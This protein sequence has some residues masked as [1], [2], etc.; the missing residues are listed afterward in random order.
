MSVINLKLVRER[1]GKTVD[2][3]ASAVGVSHSTIVQWENNPNSLSMEKLTQYAS[4]LG[5]EI[6][7]LLKKSNLET[8][9]WE[10]VAENKDLQ[11]K[12]IA[13]KKKINEIKTVMKSEAGQNFNNETKSRYEWTVQ[14]LQNILIMMRKPRIV[15]T[16]SS[17]SGKSTMLNS[18][19]GTNRIS[20]H[21]QPA[22]SQVIRVVHSDDKPKWM[23][24]NTVVI[25]TEANVLIES[26][27]LLDR[28]VY[29]K[30]LIEEGDERL[31]KKYGDR[32]GKDGVDLDRNPYTIFTYLD[33][34]I[35]NSVEIWDTPGISAGMDSEA[36]KEAG[37]SN[38]AQS[39]ADTIIYLSVINQFLH[40]EDIAYL[41]TMIRNLDR[42]NDF[43]EG[44]PAWQNLY[45][46]G[47]QAGIIDNHEAINKILDNGYERLKRTLPVS[48][49]GRDIFKGLRER[50]FTFAN[51]S[52][53]LSSGLVAQ[54][55]HDNNSYQKL[56]DKRA[57]KRV[58][59]VTENLQKAYRKL[60]DQ[61]TK[62]KK[63]QEA[64]RKQAEQAVINLPKIKRANAKAEKESLKEAENQRKITKSEFIQYYEDILES[65]NLVEN[66]NL[67]GF[68]NKKDDKN[69]FI[70]FIKGQSDFKLQ[71]I[72]KNSGEKYAQKYQDIAKEVQVSSDIDKEYFNFK[73]IGIAL[74]SGGIS[75]GAL[76]F[77]SMQI[78]SNL[79]L[80]LAVGSIGG[81]LTNLGIISSPIWLTTFISTTGGPILWGV[82]LSVLA[83][84]LVMEVFGKST[85]KIKLA[86]KTQSIF[87]KADAL[88]KYCLVID[89]YWDDTVEGVKK[90][91][92]A[93]DK[94]AEE[95]A[96][97][98][99]R[100]LDSSND[101]Y[102]N[103]Q[104]EQ[105]H[106]LILLF[107]GWSFK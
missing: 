34:P 40:K 68:K 48:T 41:G 95:Q 102:F 51:D 50:F 107:L 25:Q 77:L 29:D 47:S 35:L 60:D 86:K 43:E 49:D 96:H 31:L 52:N 20:T 17:D 6:T 38:Y 1:L 37:L 22:T 72:L 89:K 85:W 83:S 9:N 99:N 84:S 105:L 73:N 36:N 71:E 32:D 12:R 103:R 19:I 56:I 78:P 81:V 74:V 70:T 101:E 53:K 98:F 64:F 62:S 2:Q 90:T 3:L 10:S 15:I 24:G 88:A 13:I 42:R 79:G 8:V 61:I 54:F 46:V 106:D 39:K 5:L 11:N 63:D 33:S 59:M 58:N 91:R 23:S 44:L 82:G 80:Y 67:K 14:A 26:W 45:V 104:L 94:V 69:D 100:M 4:A 93:M 66:I 27:E 75:Y 57:I 30:Y 55:T 16:G 76:A 97:M 21:W 65:N 92:Q 7:D 87:K 18:M 28:K